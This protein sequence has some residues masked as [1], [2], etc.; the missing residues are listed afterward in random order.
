MKFLEFVHLSI[1]EATRFITPVAL[2]V[3]WLLVAF[4]ALAVL[5]LPALWAKALVPL[6]NLFQRVASSPRTALLICA[7]LP[8]AIRLL[9]LPISPVPDPSIHDEFSH[10]LLGDTLA[11]GR[12]TNPTPAL[13][14][15]FESIHIIVKPTYNSMYLPAQG[16]FLAIGQVLMGEPWVGVELA[17]ACMCAAM[18]W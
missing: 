17:I 16:V 8:V 12:L 2:A 3:E 6:K 10:L 14:Q 15:H 5:T 11:H 13:W 9:L 18:Y 7:T 4:S 1:F